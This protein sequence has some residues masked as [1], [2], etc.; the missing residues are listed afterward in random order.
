MIN[1]TLVDIYTLAIYFRQ[2]ILMAFKE[3]GGA[4]LG[5]MIGLKDVRSKDQSKRMRNES[6]SSY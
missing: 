2:Y 3:V 1:T 6:R 5:T 4:Q